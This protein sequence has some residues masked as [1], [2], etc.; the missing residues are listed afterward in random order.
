MRTSAYALRKPTDA[1]WQR[2]SA[3]RTRGYFRAGK[4]IQGADPVGVHLAHAAITDRSSELKVDE[5]QKDP[6]R[7]PLSVQQH[8]TPWDA[9]ERLSMRNDLQV[10]SRLGTFEPS[11]AE[12]RRFESG[13]PL[14]VTRLMTAGWRPRQP[15]VFHIGLRNPPPT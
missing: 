1:S 15:A 3:S 2:T 8:A 5:A 9:T 6:P 4:P 13:I 7:T 14:K 12:G 11:Q 10:E